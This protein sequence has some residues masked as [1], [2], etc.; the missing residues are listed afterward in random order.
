[1]VE[2]LEGT[3]DCVVST[4]E[5]TYLG[6]ETGRVN[7]QT[8]FMMGKVKISNVSEMLRYVKAFRPVEQR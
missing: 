4:S 6:I 5:E 2:G 7:P 1:V 3:P 8:A